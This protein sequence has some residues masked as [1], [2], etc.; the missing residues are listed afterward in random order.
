MKNLFLAVVATLAVPIAWA[1]GD[2]PKASGAPPADAIHAG[3]AKVPAV[4]DVKVAKAEGANA[5]T[6]GQ[7]YAD[8]V[9]LKGKE[10]VIRAKVVKVNAGIMGKNW[11]HLR[12]GSGSAADRRQRPPGD[13]QG[14]TQGRRRRHR[15]GHRQDGR[16]PGLGLRLQ[17]VDRGRLV[18]QVG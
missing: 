8:R 7:V 17:G 1:A 18:Q 3:V 11:V 2:M 4:A 5:R 13:Q 16:G 9:T 10:V 6:V 14:R 12:D 15:Q